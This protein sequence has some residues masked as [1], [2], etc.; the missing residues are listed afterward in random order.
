VAVSRYLDENSETI[1]S[2]SIRNLDKVAE[3]ISMQIPLIIQNNVETRSLENKKKHE[4]SLPEKSSVTNTKGSDDFV[5]SS[6]NPWRLIEAYKVV[7]AEKV[8]VAETE[9]KINDKKKFFSILNEQVQMRQKDHKLTKAENERFCK[10]QALE[11]EKWQNEQKK[12]DELE[13]EKTLALKKMRQEEITSTEQRN[14]ML[15]KQ[16][17]EQER[18]TLI[19]AKK[20]LQEEDEQ[21]RTKKLQERTKLRSIIKENGQRKAEREKI[22]KKEEEMDAKLMADMKK[23]LDKEE[24]DRIMEVNRRLEKCLM[25]ANTG[26]DAIR[27]KE[28]DDK[29][30]DEKVKREVEIK[31]R[32]ARKKESMKKKEQELKQKKINETNE[33]LLNEKR[34]NKVAQ[35]KA[36]E[37]YYAQLSREGEAYSL[38]EE[39]KKKKSAEN[40]R[41]Y[42]V[43]LK[44][45]IEDQEMKKKEIEEMSSEEK[46]IN[47]EV[48]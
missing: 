22:L 16:A 2:L 44:K 46:K 41:L 21:K 18:Q 35:E 38:Q 29:I 7:E 37:D 39:A 14:N 30:M 4:D 25:L 27:K 1:A 20:S 12:L 42:C 5:D 33:K 23:K 47:K 48:S 43:K 13:K 36:D 15:K 10:S 8:L 34:L 28:R 45:Q 6:I 19:N 32:E 11:F 26:A 9:K 31:D 17:Q 40:Q 24:E 3:Q